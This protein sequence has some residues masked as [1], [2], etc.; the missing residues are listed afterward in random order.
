MRGRPWYS[1]SAWIAGQ[2]VEH[3]G[4]DSYQIHLIS[5]GCLRP[6]VALHTV[7]NRGL[8]HH[9]VVE[10]YVKLPYNIA[11][12]NLR[13]HTIWCQMNVLLSHIMIF[14]WQEIYRQTR[15]QIIIQH[16]LLER[17]RGIVVL[18]TMALCTFNIRWNQEIYK[19]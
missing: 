3:K 4:H 16:L 6:S 8:K 17:T 19:G 7:Q 18:W 14:L 1:S 12:T 10:L 5:P 11:Y 13:L 9:S 15:Y 2:Q